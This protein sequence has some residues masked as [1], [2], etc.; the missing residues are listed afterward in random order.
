MENIFIS[1]EIIQGK[2]LEIERYIT[3]ELAN[4]ILKL[5]GSNY[6][7]VCNNMRLFADLIEKLEQRISDDEIITVK[8]NPMDSWYI[9]EEEDYT[10]E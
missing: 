7:N 10:N 2:P 9:A 6:E 1:D 5:N 8:Y 3:T 4:Q